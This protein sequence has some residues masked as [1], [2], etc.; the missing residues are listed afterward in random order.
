M[1]SDEL[2][3]S[4]R[5]ALKR[6]NFDLRPQLNDAIRDVQEIENLNADS[7]SQDDYIS[8]YVL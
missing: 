5:E 4:A 3:E 1:K 8:K 2:L 6:V 7:G